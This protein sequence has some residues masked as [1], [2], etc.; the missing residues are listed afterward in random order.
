MGIKKKNREE[1]AISTAAMPDII[2]ML[3][4][5][6]MVSTV[7]RNERGLPVRIPAAVNA[8]KIEGKRNFSYCYVDTKERISVDDKLL[9]P[10]EL[11]L[12]HI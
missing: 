11:S 9:S 7:I 12:I 2:F 3:L 6:F 1:G 10:K 5:F 8:K 4:I